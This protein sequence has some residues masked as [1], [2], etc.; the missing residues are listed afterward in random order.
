MLFLISCVKDLPF[1]VV[2]TTMN[3]DMEIWKIL[4]AVDIQYH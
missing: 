1:W 4:T 3:T 2:P